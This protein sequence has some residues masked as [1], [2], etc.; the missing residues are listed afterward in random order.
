M[1]NEFMTLETLA[2]FSG[3]VAA[4]TLIVQFTKTIVKDKFGDAYVRLY[5]LAVA[6]ILSFIFASNGMDVQGIALTVINAIVVTATANGA[7]EVIAD[8]KAQK[9][10]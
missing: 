9:S 4:V 6:L 2:T 10:K 5:T 1:M 8:P 7:Y 3:L